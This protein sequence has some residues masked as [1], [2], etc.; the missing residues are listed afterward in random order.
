MFAALVLIGGVVGVSSFN[1]DNTKKEIITEIKIKKRRRY[2]ERIF[3]PFFIAILQANP[4]LPSE[5]V[6][7]FLIDVHHWRFDIP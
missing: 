3:F 4:P 2:V 6:L 1:F 5:A 7:Q